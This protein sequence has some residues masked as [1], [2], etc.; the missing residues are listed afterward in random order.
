MILTLIVN[1]L[2]DDCLCSAKLNI[3]DLAGS[4]KVKASGATGDRL[5]EAASINLSL[6]NLA[7]VVHS[8]ADSQQK[9]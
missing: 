6:F 5:K 1:T 4:E 7:K 3:V 9:A 2:S 8:L